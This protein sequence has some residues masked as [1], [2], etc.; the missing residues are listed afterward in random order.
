MPSIPDRVDLL[1]EVPRG[2]FVKRELRDGELRTEYVSPLPSP[3]N[4]GCVPDRPGEDG[5]PVDVVVLG[6]RLPAGS[7]HSLPVVG[8]VRFVDAG[9]T[10]DKLVA[11]SSCPDRATRR[12]V[13]RFFRVYAVARRLL[14]LRRGVTGTT[15]Y[16]GLCWRDEDP[17]LA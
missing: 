1:I 6:P 11:S 5:D 13:A 17:A 9:Q 16:R 14:N 3:F 10:D 7:R 2:S 12:R 4:Y 15:E 8:V